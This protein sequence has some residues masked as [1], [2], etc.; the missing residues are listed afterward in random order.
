VLKAVVSALPPAVCALFALC[1][2]SFAYCALLFPY[3]AASFTAVS[4]CAMLC[5][6]LAAVYTVASHPREDNSFNKQAR[7][8][9]KR[10]APLIYINFTDDNRK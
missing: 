10:R 6:T 2:L 1:A 8:L 3:R 9:R 7:S 5:S 4:A